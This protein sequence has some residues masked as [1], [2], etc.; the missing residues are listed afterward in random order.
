MQ[1]MSLTT[2]HLK[3]EDV[4]WN[5]PSS[6]Q[7]MQSLLGMKLGFAIQVLDNARF[8]SYLLHTTEKESI[9]HMRWL[10]LNVSFGVLLA[11]SHLGHVCSR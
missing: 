1:A 4:F 3:F 9:A 8:I 2:N 6:S 7:K 11:V 5:N 10:T